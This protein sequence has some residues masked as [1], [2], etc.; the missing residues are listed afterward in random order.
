MI[1]S[2]LYAHLNEVYVQTGQKVTYG[3]RV[4]KMGNTGYVIPKPTKE[5]PAAGTHLHLAVV[6][7]AKKN[8][9]S[10]DSMPD[11]NIPNQQECLYFIENDLFNNHDKVLVT[12]GWLNYKNHY[13]YDII[14]Q[15]RKH[16]DL[17]WNRSFTGTVATTGFNPSYGKFIIM[18]YNTSEKTVKPS[19]IGQKELDEC[20]EKVDNLLK[21]IEKHKNA[22]TN[23][24]TEIEEYKNKINIK[25][26][27]IADYLDIIK[28]RTA[29]LDKICQESNNKS[30]EITKINNNLT[31]LNEENN[32]LKSKI[33]KLEAD[34]ALI[35]GDMPK[36][37]FECPKSAIYTIKLRKGYKLYIKD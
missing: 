2:V 10:L 31:I 25:N 37:I 28:I 32:F 16:Y 17:Y 36:Q 15:N 19:T 26:A 4:A 11:I 27:E 35:P 30:N 18:H 34:L 24:T 21:E 13:A 23:Q 33:E 3:Q 20:Q 14:P 1:Y 12:A 9:W 29:E 8:P 22:I 5:N 6:E 7:G